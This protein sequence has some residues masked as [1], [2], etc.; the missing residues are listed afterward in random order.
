[1]VRFNQLTFY[2]YFE[3]KLIARGSMHFISVRYFQNNIE[4]SY[5]LK[6]K[7]FEMEKY[8]GG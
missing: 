7:I 8:V 5:D 3:E 4:E 6:C 2:A 1:M